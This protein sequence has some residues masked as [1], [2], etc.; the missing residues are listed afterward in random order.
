M[1]QSTATL[2]H[3]KP[4]VEFTHYCVFWD[5]GSSVGFLEVPKYPYGILL[6]I[7]EKG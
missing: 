4:P 2:C 1:T 3:L 5:V 6:Q 7:I